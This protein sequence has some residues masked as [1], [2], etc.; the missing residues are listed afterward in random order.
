MGEVL[1]DY[2]REMLGRINEAWKSCR[3]V[4]VQMP[5]GTGKTVLMT[6]VIKS[7]QFTVDGV[8][9]TRQP[10]LVVAHRRELIEQIRQTLDRRT[11]G[12][13]NLEII[14]TE[15]HNNKDRVTEGQQN[16]VS[17]TSIQK[18]ARAKEQSSLLNINFSLIIVD[19]AHHA[20]AESYRWMWDQWPE[21]KFLGLTATPYRL[22]GEG[23]TDLF[24]VLLQSESIQSFIE[25]GWL[26]DFE[27]VSVTPENWMLEK[28][29]GL[30][31]RGVDGDYQTK[32][33]ATVMDTE[34]RSSL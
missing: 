3:S 27:Y 32:E 10:V 26:S 8:Q 13:N 9:S 24:D 21:A 14:R 12:Y 22:S 34:Y 17:V 4:M 33:M 11:K 20:V 25:K 30:K 5:T 6:E 29:H 15:G 16:F 1:R 28:I 18:L 2:Q 23:F 7:L 31:K 19:E